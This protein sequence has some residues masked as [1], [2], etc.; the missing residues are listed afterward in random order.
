MANSEKMQAL[1]LVR[2]AKNLVNSLRTGD[3]KKTL[4][5][6]FLSLW[7]MEDAI[8]HATTK[9]SLGKMKRAATHL[10]KVNAELNKNIVEL[11]E[12]A[13]K[14]KKATEAVKL[15]VNILENAAK[16]AAIV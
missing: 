15:L 12:V 11:K 16:L 9:Q 6:V 4:S 8:M 2:E 5:K 7:K 13:D 3:R 14:V 1:M 10:K